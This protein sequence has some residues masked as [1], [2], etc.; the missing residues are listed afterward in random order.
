MGPQIWRILAALVAALQST[1]TGAQGMEFHL[2]A[3]QERYVVGGPIHLTW[4]LTNRTGRAWLVLASDGACDAVVVRIET[5]EGRPIRQFPLSLPRTSF[6]PD[7]AEL[8]PDASVTN[9]FDLVAFAGLNGLSL[10]PGAYRLNASYGFAS[11]SYP[12]PLNTT[13]PQWRGEVVAPPLLLII[14]AR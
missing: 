12:S 14:R 11:Y 6:Q 8:A 1:G 9:A 2:A 4:T 3:L 5:L 7:F 10:A 13:A